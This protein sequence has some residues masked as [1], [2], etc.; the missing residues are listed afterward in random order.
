MT[1]EY[2]KAEKVKL[3]D[4]YGEKWLQERIEED[5]SILGLGDLSIVQRE[6]PV[7]RGG[8][9]DFLFIDHETDTMYETEIQLGATDESHIIRT[10]EY[11]DIEK[12]R[13]PSKDHRA[14]IVAEDITNRFFNVIS[15]F[16]RAIPIIAIQLNSLKV[17]GKIILNFIK[18]LDIYEP[19][20]DE[21]DLSGE[22]VDRA[23]WESRADIESIKLMDSLSEIAQNHYSDLKTTYNKHH[24]AIGTQLRNFMWFHPRKK[25]GYVYFDVRVTDD[26]LEPLKNILDEAAISY[27]LKGRNLGVPML[28]KDFKENNEKIVDLITKAM[29][30]FI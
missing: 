9:L 25:K 3:R 6:R 12:R 10:I 16:N 2:F 8:R 30:P 27:N 23:Y 29:A 7:S 20:E 19:P 4:H 14:V 17:D 26:T 18:V 13:F 21:E 5:P 1:L 11:W 15:L 28:K 24:V 22:T